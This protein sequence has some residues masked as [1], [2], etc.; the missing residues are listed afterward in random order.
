MTRCQLFFIKTRIFMQID[1][2]HK[3]TDR[4]LAII[5]LYLVMFIKINIKRLNHARNV[6]IMKQNDMRRRYGACRAMILF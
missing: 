2:F 6:N 1:K 3:M 5:S 4:F